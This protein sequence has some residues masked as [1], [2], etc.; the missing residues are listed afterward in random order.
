MKVSKLAFDFFVDAIFEL[1][2][3]DD[4]AAHFLEVVAN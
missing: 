2:E 4:L 1:F 3:L